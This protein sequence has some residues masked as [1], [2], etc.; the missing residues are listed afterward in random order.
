MYQATIHN[1]RYTNRNIQRAEPIQQK[2]S[3]LIACWRKS[4]ECKQE[5]NKPEN[6]VDGLDWKFRHGEKERE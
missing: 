2:Y 1:Q 6:G 5:K 4:V 3:R